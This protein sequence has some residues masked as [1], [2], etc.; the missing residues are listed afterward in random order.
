MP[1]SWRLAFGTLT[2]IRVPAP[3]VVDRGVARGAMLLAPAVGLVL[4]ALAVVV[5]DGVRLLAP[6]SRP[7]VGVDLLAAVLAVGALALLT[8]GLHLD[9]LADTADGLGVKGAGPDAA[10]RRLEVMRAPD[11][12]A[13]GV[14]TT[15]LVLLVEVAALTVCSTAGAGTVGLLGA[16]VLSRLAATWCATPLLSPARTDGLGSVVSRTVPVAAALAVTLLT[17]AGL[18][19]LGLLDDDG[20]PRL[21]LA[22]VGAA[23]L[24]L[25]AAATVVLRAVRRF[26]GVT[27]DLIGAAVEV[28]FATMLVVVALA[29]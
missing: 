27:G 8:R 9:G 4:G 3:R 21:A 12:G 15:V 19:V 22:L 25:G 18:V 20:G 6:D 5:L 14:A 16:M 10:S 23:V 2:A 7:A 11:V 26:G 24:G 1:D 28:S 17:A 13:F 29:A